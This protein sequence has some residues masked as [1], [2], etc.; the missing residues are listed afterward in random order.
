MTTNI[1]EL[2]PEKGMHP[3]NVLLMYTKLKDVEKLIT[4]VNVITTDGDVIDM[5]I[6]ITA[7]VKTFMASWLNIT[8]ENGNNDDNNEETEDVD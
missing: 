1:N 3:D 7:E 6:E 2:D 5:A 4:N 8:Q